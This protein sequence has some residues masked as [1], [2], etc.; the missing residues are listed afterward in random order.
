MASKVRGER[1]NGRDNEQNNQH[2]DILARNNS[3][4]ARQSGADGFTSPA[5][6]LAESI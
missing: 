2:V 3:Y 5:S 4:R 6:D 1:G